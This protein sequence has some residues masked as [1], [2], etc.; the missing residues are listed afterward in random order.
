MSLS[1][2]VRFAIAFS[3]GVALAAIGLCGIVSPKYALLIDYANG[4][5]VFNCNGFVFVYGVDLV[6]MSLG[7]LLIKHHEPFAQ[8]FMVLLTILATSASVTVIVFICTFN[9]VVEYGHI[10]VLD[11]YMR[12]HDT[13]VD[14]WQGIIRTD[15]N[16]VSVQNGRAGN[17]CFSTNEH[18]YCAS[19][20]NEYY[21]DEPTFI[22]LHRFEIVFMLIAL[23]LL[24]AW[25]L[26]KLYFCNN[27]DHYN[28]NTSTK[29][30][31]L[32]SSSS[33]SSESYSEQRICYAVP[34]NNR[35]VSRNR[36]QSLLLMPSPQPSW[37]FDA[38]ET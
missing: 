7:M 23:L 25:T 21:R 11:V 32:A 2:I 9:W 10:A 12:T 36:E 29:T 34:T 33:S 38:H 31:S 26:W 24:N 22:K 18:T 37:I 16:S 17:N 5:P 1:C 28:E 30:S 4:S 19:C 8:Y 6:L 20:R 3:V 27:S 15:F 14:C 13:E 35:P